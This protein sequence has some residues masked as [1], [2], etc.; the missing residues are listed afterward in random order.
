MYCLIATKFLI[1]PGNSK[2]EEEA[3]D[4]VLRRMVVT[5]GSE[6]DVTVAEFPAWPRRK[7]CI[8]LRAGIALLLNVAAATAGAGGRSAVVLLAVWSPPCL[9]LRSSLSWG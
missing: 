4:K 5:A 3:A 7:I 2:E 1:K 6:Q 9:R 8:S